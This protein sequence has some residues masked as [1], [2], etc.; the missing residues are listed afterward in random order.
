MTEPEEHWRRRLVTVAVRDYE[1]EPP[2]FAKRIDDQVAVLSR[3]L[4]DPALSGREFQHEELHPQSPSCIDDFV[5]SKG[6]D[7]AA[8]DDVLVVYVTGHGVVG[9]SGHHYLFLPDSDQDQP[10]ATCYPTSRLLADVLGSDAEHV[11]IIVDSCHAGALHAEWAAL[12][13]DLPKS[14]R[15]LATLAVI[16]SADFDFKPRIGEFAKLLRLVH[17][18]LQGPAQVLGR[19]LTLVELLTEIASVRAKHPALGNPMLIWW[20]P[21][22]GQNDGTPCLPN[23]GYKPPVDLVDHPRRQV[24][25]T[26]PELDEYWISR[27]SGRVSTQD[28]GWYFSGRADLMGSVV[29]FLN[30]GDGIL[31]I[32]GV[33]GSGKS[34]ILARTVTLSDQNFRG[35]NPEVTDSIA[36]SVVPPLGCI[37]AAV[38][39]REKDNEQ[40]CTELLELLGGNRGGVG[41]AYDELKDHLTSF[42]RPVTIVVDGIDEATHPDRLV[43]EVLGPLARVRGS[44]KMAP[45]RLLLGVRSKERSSAIVDPSPDL[46]DLLGRAAAATSLRVLRS[47]EKPSVTADVAAYLAALLEVSGPYAGEMSPQDPVVQIVASCVSPSFL[48]A[49]LAG[50]RLRDGANK[51]DVSDA[52]WLDTLA[53]GTLSLFRADLIDTARS[54]KR[55]LAH[56]LAVL[57]AT[58]FA[59]GRGLPWGDVWPVAAAA[60]LDEPIEDT[61]QLI[62][63]VLRS[64]LTGYL[65]QDVEDGR[66]VHRPNHERLAEELR[67]NA[68]ALLE[69]GNRS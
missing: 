57:R 51:Q 56:V 38:L 17:E 46:L 47:D 23:P 49:R 53:D 34:A 5:K 61:D 25:V 13:K 18:R 19:Y 11:L 36:A 1:D 32:T 43:A 44:D 62:A 42:A 15:E 48:D 31:V 64:R 3:W 65:A 59:F 41:E 10:L 69:M 28:P 26:Q 12:R 27:A 22:F 16:A 54:I 63:A 4:T 50:E 14:R 20:S 24:A 2:E 52:T 37:D 6:L 68:A 39:A 40:V 60:V 9:G 66:I 45:L 33:A 30:S 58:A 35:N 21:A 29:Q 55:P 7:S 8:Q 67:S